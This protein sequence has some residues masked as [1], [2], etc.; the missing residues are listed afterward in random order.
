VFL[1]PAGVIFL[2]ESVSGGMVVGVALV[3]IGSLVVNR[4]LF[5]KGPLEP[6]RAIIREP[7]SRYMV[8]VAA[9]LTVTNLLAKWF[10]VSDGGAVTFADKMQLALTLSVGK[11][12]MLA[13]FFI[14]LVIISQGL[15]KAESKSPAAI[16]RAVS[17]IPWTGVLR[18][19]PRWLILAGILEALVLVL[20]LVAMQFAVAA[21]V[22]AIKRSAVIWSVLLGWLMFKERNIGDRLIASAVMASG[23]IPQISV[24]MGPCAGGA[25]YSP[26]MT[27]FIYM[28]RDSSYM[29]V[30]GPDVVKTVTNE[31]VTAEELGG[32][33]THTRKSSV[34][35]GAFENDVEALTEIRRLFGNFLQSFDGP[36]EI[37]G[38]DFLPFSNE[39]DFVF[40]KIR[41]VRFSLRDHGG[42][43][44]GPFSGIHGDGAHVKHK[45]AGS[46]FGGNV[47]RLDGHFHRPLAF[48]RPVGGEFV[49]VG[50]IDHH[51]DGGGEVVVDARTGKKA[52]FECLL[53]AWQFGDGHA[54]RQLDV[55][56][57]EFHN[58]LDHF[59]A[60][61][62]AT[63]VPA[64]RKR[65]HAPAFNRKR[66]PST[67]PEFQELRAGGYSD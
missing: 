47:E 36:V 15:R 62:V 56:K 57:A 20:M 54:M 27:D 29:F 26:A 40:D 37:D 55:V 24:I 46:E 11:C 39:G 28:V 12:V 14:L 2:D 32:A 58:F 1:L 45:I 66:P 3:V 61:R 21:V 7:G 43:S 35:D 50:S 17:D 48:E 23:V 41:V 31:V 30:T 60:V 13:V 38:S 8:M 67:N 63:V 34:A 5:A 52:P 4:E 51:F 64:G 22:V 25:V 49:G 18:E 16:A 9:L 19:S 65:K 59:L 42:E 10:L 33:S 53:D 6:L 44:F